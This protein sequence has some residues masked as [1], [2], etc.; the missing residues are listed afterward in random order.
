M[1]WISKKTFILNR[2]LWSRKQIALLLAI[3]TLAP[4]AAYLS[5]NLA[6][7]RPVT[8]A[9]MSDQWKCTKTAG[10]VTVCTKKPG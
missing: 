8:S 4:A 6:R 5:I 10:I 3:L 9:V 7:P 1:T 2:S